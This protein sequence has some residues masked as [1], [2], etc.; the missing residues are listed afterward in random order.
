MI[1]HIWI[2][3]LTLGLVTGRNMFTLLKAELGQNKAEVSR[4]I[5]AHDIT[6]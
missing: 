4:V 1:C 3:K 2:R 5:W 6:K